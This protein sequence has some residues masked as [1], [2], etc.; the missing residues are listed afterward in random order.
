MFL[1]LGSRVARLGLYTDVAS[2]LIYSL[3]VAQNSEVTLELLH[4]LE[5]G[6]FYMHCVDLGPR[7]IVI[8]AMVGR[9]YDLY[10]VA[11]DVYARTGLATHAEWGMAEVDFLV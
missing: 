5:H 9:A 3:N 11:F 7:V 8:Q 10:V 6:M 4:R 1:P 2:R